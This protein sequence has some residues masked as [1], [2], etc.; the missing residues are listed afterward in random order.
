MNSKNF[1]I[2]EAVISILFGI[3]LLL[4]PEGFLSSYMNDG[5]S[6][7]PVARGVARAYGGILAG[8][9]IIAWQNRFAQGAVRKNL[10]LGLIVINLTA[11]VAYLIELINSQ[12]NSMAW[13]SVGI[14][15]VLGI[16]ALVLLI[17][18][19]KQAS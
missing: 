13:T 10:L 14:C 1:F 4:I 5:D 2:A 19:D 6:L 16:W 15:A 17:S 7:G 8:V 12:V 11:G 18:N 9:G 3:A